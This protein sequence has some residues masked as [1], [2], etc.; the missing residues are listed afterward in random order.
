MIDLVGIVTPSNATINAA[1]YAISFSVAAGQGVVNGPSSG[2]YAVPVGGATGGQPE[3]LTGNYGS[4]LTTNVGASGNYLSTGTGS[5]TITFTS[6]KY[7]FAMLWGSIDSFN[8]VTL[9][10]GATSIGVVTGTDAAA[11]LGN[12]FTATGGQGA[13]GSGYIILNSA[14]AFNAITFSSTTPSFEFTGI[15]GSTAQIGIPEPMGLALF[16]SGLL[17]IALVR[18]RRA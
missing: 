3:Y 18:R 15:V 16:G 1:G 5:I 4:S 12:G 13:G 9:L 2:N 6:N 11:A 8:T 7:A 14:S 17:G 10:Q